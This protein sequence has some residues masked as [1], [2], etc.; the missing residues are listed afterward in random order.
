V[1]KADNPF[2]ASMIRKVFE[3]F[4]APIMPLPF[5][6]CHVGSPSFQSATWDS[7]GYTIP[8]KEN[9]N[10]IIKKGVFIGPF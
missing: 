5:P 1:R 8:G 9:L 4:D 7:V 2:L 10:F 6:S 3:E